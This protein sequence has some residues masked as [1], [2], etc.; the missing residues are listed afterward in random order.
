MISIGT[1]GSVPPDQQVKALHLYVDESD[2]ILAKPQLMAVY[3]SKPTPTH[4][5]LLHVWMQLVPEIETIL[6]TKGRDNADWLQAC[7]NTWLAEKLIYIKT[8]EI[9]LLDHYSLHVQM[10]LHTV[11]MSLKHPT[12]NKFALFHTIDWHWIKKCHVLTVLKS[13]ETQA[14]AMIAGMLPYL[15]WKYGTDD[16][17]KGYI[18]KWFKPVAHA[19][20]ADA[21]WDPKEE[22]VKNTSNKMLSEA[23]V[24]DDDLYWA[25]EKPAPD[26][27]SPKRKQVQLEEELLDN[28][29]S[30][31][32]LGLSMKKTKKSIL[33]N[34]NSNDSKKDA[35]T[36]ASQATTISQLMKQVNEINKQTRL[37]LSTSTNWPNK[38]LHY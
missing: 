31:I 15:Q 14:W 26:P 30:T 35:S 18:T 3:T 9:E 23:L 24:E 37:F 25:A 27:T 7:Q 34:S 36:V 11:M 6:N 22:C 33:K 17:K 8:W 2:I 5:S 4:M 19:C 16:T 28:T 1:Q 20:T 13:A 38:Q 32:K 10:N 21:F 29:V 12:N